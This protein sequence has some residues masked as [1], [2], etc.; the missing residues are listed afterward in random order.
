M[1]AMGESVA[2]KAR[3]PIQR[4]L[5]AAAAAIDRQ[6]RRE[7]KPHDEATRQTR[8]RL[9]PDPI[10]RLFREKSLTRRQVGAANDIAIG[11]QIITAP[12]AIKIA[13]YQRDRI[14][15]GSQEAERERSVALQR[16][17][18][19]WQAG[20]KR[21]NLNTMP[22]MMVVVDGIGLSEIAKLM[23]VREASILP[24]VVTALNFYIRVA[25]YC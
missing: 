19:A 15:G 5:V 14:G 10:D 12:V 18:H 3:K 11:H 4:Q 6:K 1:L 13:S 25:R 21:V 20:M 2:R 22:V 23:R 9:R 16:R 7:R 8:E 24:L 17:Y